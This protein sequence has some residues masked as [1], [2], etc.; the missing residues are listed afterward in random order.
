MF[1][2]AQ[3]G[4][5]VPKIL[6][7][8]PAGGGKTK[9]A[10][11]LMKGLVG[12]KTIAL[13]DTENASSTIY[14]NEFEFLIAN[15]P[16]SEQNV[17][18]YQRAMNSAITDAKA[19]GVIVD[20]ITPAW[21]DILDRSNKMEGNSFTNW[22]KLTPI[23]ESFKDFIIAYQVPLICTVRSKQGYVLE[24]NEKGKTAPKKVGLEM[25]QGK[26]ID[27][28]FDIV[29]KIDQQ[30]H[31]ASIDKCRYTEVEDYFNQNQGELLLTEEVGEIIRNIVRND[32]KAV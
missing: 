8:G 22:G 14:A 19:S 28:D 32:T 23:Q 31:L 12:N 26:D 11:R 15:L 2:K 13:I 20:S 25:E 21:K 6:L 17:A 9:S 29:F 7:T 3:R 1:Q 27:Y 5:R 16:K 18:G 10:L 4:T 30:T 24:V